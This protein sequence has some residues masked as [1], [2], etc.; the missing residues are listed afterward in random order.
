MFTHRQTPARELMGGDFTDRIISPTGSG[1][2]CSLVETQRKMRHWKELG[3]FTVFNAG[4]FDVLGLN[5]VR[6]LV[7]CRALG[8]MSLLGIEKIET[9]VDYQAVH[10][11][12]ASDQ[13]GLMITIDTNKALEDGKS[14]R[15]DKGNAPKPTLDWGTRAAMLAVQSMPAL[16]YEHRINLV[17]YITRH[18]PGCC[19]VCAGSACTNE[20]NARMA[21][22]L[23]PDLVVVNTGSKQT[24]ADLTGY[25]QDGQLS[26]TELVTIDE[27]EGAFSDQVLGGIISTTAI[28]NRIRS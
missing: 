12:A 11:V 21:A 23:Q 4:A 2:E 26:G 25:K 28:I 19:A 15:L 22:A 17:D 3:K 8:A 9:Q 1:G 24:I 27:S 6:G 13:I 10:R 7:Q 16:G 14:R 5:H 20:D 18:G